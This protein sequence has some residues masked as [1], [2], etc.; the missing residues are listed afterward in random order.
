[1]SRRYTHS[2][3]PQNG[4]IN[5]P[6]PSVSF[7][8]IHEAG[9]WGQV[10]GYTRSDR[11]KRL[12]TNDP[13][14]LSQLHG[15][16]NCRSSRLTVNAGVVQD[17]YDL[18]DPPKYPTRGPL[19][20]RVGRSMYMYNWTTGSRITADTHKQSGFKGNARMTFSRE[21]N[22]RAL[23]P[24]IP[25]IYC[26]S[27]R[28]REHVHL[29]YTVEFDNGITPR[30]VRDVFD[31]DIPLCGFY[32]FDVHRMRVEQHAH[33]PLNFPLP[34]LLPMPRRC[35][36]PD[37]EVTS[38]PCKH[39]IAAGHVSDSI[40]TSFLSKFP[41]KVDGNGFAYCSFR[42]HGAIK[43]PSSAVEGRGKTV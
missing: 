16:E 18:N 19:G 4:G 31:D 42:E 20:Q 27:Q 15:W 25:Y 38:R 7:T 10:Y 39:M 24:H 33:T 11:A 30:T 8:Q 14:N 26:H 29:T 41:I 17:L 37:Y 3:P 6:A 12:V 23:F 21:S 2:I 13:Y 43:N 22:T 28:W 36:C 32:N 9:K 5:V 40:W 34:D 1:M 35:N